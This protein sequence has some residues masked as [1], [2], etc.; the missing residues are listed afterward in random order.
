MEKLKKN[1]MNKRSKKYKMSKRTWIIL[2]VFIVVIIGVIT[3][4]L[5][6]KNS[7]KYQKNKMEKLV[8]KWAE[9]YYTEELVDIASGYIKLKASKGESISINLDSLKNFGKD[10]EIIKNKKTGKTCDDINTYVSIKVDKNAKD[11]SKDYEI[12]EV[13]LDCFE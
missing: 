12:E 5:A 3:V 9:E 8:S 6:N 1:K 11:I 10:I 4:C 2:A 7:E 13:V